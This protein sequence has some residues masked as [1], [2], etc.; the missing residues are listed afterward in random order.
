MF[1][2]VHP[3]C[4]SATFLVSDGKEYRSI[5][6]YLKLPIGKLFEILTNRT[7]KMNQRLSRYNPEKFPDRWL[8]KAI[9]I[10]T[11]FPFLWIAPN[12][13]AIFKGRPVRIILS[14][15]WRAIKGERIERAFSRACGIARV[16]RVGVLPFEQYQ[17]VESNRL[18]NCRG[19]FAFEDTKTGQIKFIPT[20]TWFRFRQDVLKSVTDKYGVV[21]TAAAK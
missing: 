12:Y 14:T 4:E 16:L 10:K 11:L 5:N 15:L 1:G 17:A 7:K 18:A 9:V 8:G 21:P 2:G 19:A 13:S 20:C 6:H 3:N